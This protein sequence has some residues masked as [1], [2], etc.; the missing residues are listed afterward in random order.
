MYEGTDTV[1]LFEELACQDTL[2]VAWRPLTGAI[3]AAYAGSLSERN[4]RLLQACAAIED[5][6]GADREDDVSPELLRIDAK[7]N[8]LLDLM[9]QLLTAN[10]PRPNAVPVRFNTHGAMW[11]ATAPV[12]APGS[13]G[14]VLLYLR[15]YLPEALRLIGRIT[16]TTADG[17]VKVR[18][19]PLGE[20]TADLMEKMIFRHHRRRIAGSRRA[21]SPPATPRS[22]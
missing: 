20:S 10:R 6:A 1:V 7:I 12:P 14:I 13:Q 19:A 4:A 8:L 3:D 15:D 11:R 17:Q 5:H 22:K 21:P 16:E 18:F 9:G 2:P